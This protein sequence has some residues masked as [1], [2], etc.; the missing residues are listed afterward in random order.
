[1]NRT[2]PQITQSWQRAERQGIKNWIPSS[3]SGIGLRN[4]RRVYYRNGR[5]APA[6]AA[7]IQDLLIEN[8]IGLAKGLYK[9]SGLKSIV[10]NPGSLGII[11]PRLWGAMY[12]M[13]KRNLEALAINKQKTL[14]KKEQTNIAR[15]QAALLTED[16][17]FDAKPDVPVEESVPVKENVPVEVAVVTNNDNEPVIKNNTTVAKQKPDDKQS[18]PPPLEQQIQ[19][20]LQE[21][22]KRVKFKARNSVRQNKQRIK[23]IKNSSNL[24]IGTK[25]VGENST[26]VD[27]YGNVIAPRVKE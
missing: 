6:S 9:F 12:Q 22:E 3:G 21:K 15:N 20:Q 8:P 27:R 17:P 11:D 19:K 14:S 7:V 25:W 16:N 1:M 13:N 10:D 26:W 23:D 4:G 24:G 2:R 18:P 5:I